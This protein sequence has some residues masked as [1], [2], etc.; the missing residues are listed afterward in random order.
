LTAIGIGAAAGYA[1]YRADKMARDSVKAQIAGQK[2]ATAQAE[3]QAN[4]A[5]QLQTEE[6]NRANRRNADVAG[7]LSGIQQQA[8]GGQSGTLLTGAQGVDNSALTLGKTTLL[9]G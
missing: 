1:G 7:I 8:K 2:E 4:Q 6:T 5:A 3:K 9:G